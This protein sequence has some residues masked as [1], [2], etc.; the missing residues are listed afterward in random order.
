[1]NQRYRF[2]VISGIAATTLLVGWLSF[3]LSHHPAT[4]PSVAM[5]PNTPEQPVVP[6]KQSPPIAEASADTNKAKSDLSPKDREAMAF[7]YADD[8][9]Q[10]WLE[11]WAANH[12]R[13]TAPDESQLK[14]LREILHQ[15]PLSAGDLMTVAQGYVKKHNATIVASQIYHA[16]A[17]KM[18][19]ELSDANSAQKTSGTLNAFIKHRQNIKDVLWARI[20]A[21]D[22]TSLETLYSFYSNFIKFA[23]DNKK[24][25][26]GATAQSVRTG[27]AECLYLRGDVDQALELIQENAKDDTLGGERRT[28]L[29][30]CWAL[31]L[32]AK[33]DE[34][35]AAKHAFV[36][37]CQPEFRYQDKAFQLYISSLA[38]LQRENLESQCDFTRYR[39]QFG[40]RVE[41][42]QPAR[43][44]EDKLLEARL[45]SLS[46]AHASISSEERDLIRSLLQKCTWDY[47][48]LAKVGFALADD[49]YKKEVSPLFFCE[50]ITRLE[51]RKA[52][53]GEIPIEH[54]RAMASILPLLW[55]YAERN[56]EFVFLDGI[57]RLSSCITGS[58]NAGRDSNV[59]NYAELSLIQADLIEGNVDDVQQRVNRLR[60][61]TDASDLNM[62]WGTSLFMIENGFTKQGE[63]VLTSL[64]DCNSFDRQEG[65]K[66]VLAILK[67][68]ALRKEGGVQVQDAP[69]LSTLRFP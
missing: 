55:P 34:L 52:E 39:A 12:D 31:V 3:S 45:D 25:R 13:D 2:F 30:W 1:M 36:V 66:G 68:I 16:A 48:N 17:E 32:Q 23:G 22:A 41:D 46:D 35:G 26:I 33:H 43:S 69:D 28:A 42:A 14:E 50:S 11:K 67:N 37:A 4:F 18:E 64:A 19:V 24:G 5:S 38:Q 20:D 10:T 49:K 8:R 59:V 53:G 58:L 21:G 44:F 29:E 56:H 7:V 15:S 63:G 57:R 65:A 40:D 27:L 9:L 61:K 62:A 54:I 6:A 60:G 47:A 51:R